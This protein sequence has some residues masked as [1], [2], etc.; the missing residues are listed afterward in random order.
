MLKPIVSFSECRLLNRVGAILISYLI[1]ELPLI[2]LLFFF[3]N[4]S[5]CLFGKLPPINEKISQLTAD[6][7]DFMN[8]KLGLDPDTSTTW[9][10]EN[11]IGKLNLP[12]KLVQESFQSGATVLV[13]TVLVVL[14][15]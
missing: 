5:R 3:F 14:M 4:Q 13:N 11:F 12:I 1:A 7:M 15:A 6:L 9:L 10:A 8:Q 2:E